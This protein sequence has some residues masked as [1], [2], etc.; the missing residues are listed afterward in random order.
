LLVLGT[1]LAH[2]GR[3]LSSRILADSETLFAARAGEGRAERGQALDIGMDA[4]H[5][6]KDTNIQSL[7][8]SFPC[9]Y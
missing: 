4:T 3:A 6:T 7:I 5:G 1:I 8:F 2:P 9:G